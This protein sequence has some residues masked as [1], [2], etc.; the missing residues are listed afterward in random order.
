VL[1]TLFALCL[2]EENSNVDN[3]AGLSIRDGAK[4]TPTDGFEKSEEDGTDAG[5]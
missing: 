2:K 1:D 3:E 5:N 4:I